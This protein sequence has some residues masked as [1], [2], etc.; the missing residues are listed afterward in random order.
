MAYSGKWN[1]FAFS[2]NSYA[3]ING[4]YK[5]N[6]TSKT[7]SYSL[8]SFGPAFQKYFFAAVFESAHAVYC[9]LANELR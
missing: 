6:G 8:D 7:V 1:F 2:I 9:N 3:R 5:K 4:F